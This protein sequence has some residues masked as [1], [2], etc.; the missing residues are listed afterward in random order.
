VGDSYRDLI[1]SADTIVDI[2]TKSK[3]VVDTIQS[4]ERR[5]HALSATSLASEQ[6]KKHGDGT[7]TSS[8]DKLFALANSVKFIIDTPEVIYNYLDSGEFLSAAQR[9]LMATDVHRSLSSQA[10]DRSS[11]AT[12]RFPLLRHHWPLVKKLGSESWDRAIHW[13]SS[14]Q[15]SRL[16]SS[17]QI[18]AVLASLALLRPV[19]GAD[20]LRHLL[21]SRREYLVNHLKQQEQEKEKERGEEDSSKPLYESVCHVAVVICST[22]AECGKLFLKRP[23]VTRRPLI[24]DTLVGR[25]LVHPQD[26]VS[27]PQHAETKQEQREHD[28]VMRLEELTSDGVAL[29]CSQ[30]LDTLPATL[31]PLLDQLLEKRCPSG[32]TL[33]ALENAVQSTLASWEMRLE[34]SFD[35]TQQTVV[36]VL[37]WRDLCQWTLGRPVPL[38][39]LLFEGPL[40]SRAKTL[41]QSDFRAASEAVDGALR[42]TLQN[43]ESTDG[44]SATNVAPTAVDVAGS[45]WILRAESLLSLVNDRLEAARLAA[46]AVVSPSASTSPVGYYGEQP[47]TGPTSHSATMIQPSSSSSSSSIATFVHATCLE[48]IQNIVTALETALQGQTSECVAMF[49]GR[50]AVGLADKSMALHVLLGP[51]SE[52]LKRQ[53]SQAAH[54]GGESSS[55]T[56][57]EVQQRLREV[58]Q[59]AYEHWAD[60]VSQTLVETYRESVMA[61]NKHKTRT[62]PLRV[63]R[64]LMSS[65]HPVAASAALMRVASDACAHINVAGGF[66]ADQVAID[67]LKKCLIQRFSDC[68]LS[69]TK[70]LQDSQDNET[71]LLGFLFDVDFLWALCHGRRGLPAG[72][73]GPGIKHQTKH[74]L[75]TDSMSSQQRIVSSVREDIVSKLDPV[76]WGTLESGWTKGV[77]AA[78][79]LSHV[80]L[81]MLADDT[82]RVPEHSTADQKVEQNV[83]QKDGNI[84]Q[85]AAPVAARFAYLPASMPQGALLQRRAGSSQFLAQ[86]QRQA[87]E[88]LDLLQQ[89]TIVEQ[90]SDGG[91]RSEASDA[92]S[93]GFGSLG[94]AKNTLLRSEQHASGSAVSLSRTVSRSE[95]GVVIGTVGKASDTRNDLVEQRRGLGATALEV[96]RTSALGSLL[97]DKAAEVT[98]TLGEY[99]LSLSTQGG[100]AQLLSSLGAPF[101]RGEGQ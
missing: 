42:E 16:A 38:G 55:V 80:L 22:I 10:G 28:A 23:G 14:P 40:L 82:W 76:V 58:G 87:K 100:A 51:A 13:L 8:Y 68:I 73:S 79:V 99:S 48:A 3:H 65:S 9:Y 43:A 44:T 31:G 19:H 91:F 75:G 57:L 32:E 11:L 45:L 94:I 56:F 35:K 52:W 7:V 64:A 30:W 83:E 24:I 12:Q 70:D 25:E 60:I 18:A 67:T 26:L 93:Y 90:R 21:R 66:E 59:H 88:M 97:G 63:P 95:E 33:R 77:D 5:I 50:I 37:G 61:V 74:R 78:V 34:G 6:K 53:S 71:L 41:I 4:L 27:G 54:Q 29:E 96:W 86:Q 17:K 69:L 47:S 46:L 20:V 84:L 89:V 72:Y 98:A 85:T 81:G 1:A 49:L 36:E 2:A 39:P 101:G 92:S 62:S 15:G